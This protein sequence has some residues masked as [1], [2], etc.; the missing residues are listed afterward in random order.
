MGRYEE[1]TARRQSWS[2]S[3]GWACDRGMATDTRGLFLAEI[4][5]FSPLRKSVMR[6]TA[7]AHFGPTCRPWILESDT[8][9]KPTSRAAQLYFSQSGMRKSEHEISCQ[10][11]FFFFLPKRVV[12][13]GGRTSWSFGAPSLS[14]GRAASGWICI[15]NYKPGGRRPRCVFKAE[16]VVPFFT[17]CPRGL[18]PLLAE[19]RPCC[20][21]GVA[22][23]LWRRVYSPS[24]RG[25]KMGPHE[26]T[27]AKFCGPL[28]ITRCS[29]KPN[30]NRR[31]IF[32]KKFPT[33]ARSPFL[34]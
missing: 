2:G 8:N 30:F 26:R 20:G 13:A 23:L 7:A 22:P 16:M 9:P 10:I 32:V 3:V 27:S 4:F 34:S 15:A 24:H 5:F 11:F 12:S 18:G 17:P 6:E 25:Q 31:Y 28:S 21:A 29:G 14:G 19:A 1:R 33:S